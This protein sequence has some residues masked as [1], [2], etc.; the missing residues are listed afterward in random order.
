MRPNAGVKGRQA[1]QR[2]DVPLNNL[3]GKGLFGRLEKP[4]SSAAC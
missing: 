3:L 1:A 4:K 2:I